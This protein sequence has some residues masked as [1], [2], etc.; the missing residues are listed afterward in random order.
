MAQATITHALRPGS[1]AD[2]IIQG[3][4]A[5]PPSSRKRGRHNTDVYRIVGDAAKLDFR[6]VTGEGRLLLD[7][8][9][10]AEG[11][12]EERITAL[13]A[14]CAAEVAEI[15]AADDLANATALGG[16]GGGAEGAG[17]A[18]E[19]AGRSSPRQLTP[20]GGAPSLGPPLSPIPPPPPSPPSSYRA[21]QTRRR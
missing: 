20:G 17:A 9:G 18:G 15:D 2:I 3:S 1:P 14:V 12:K 10:I 11:L 4:S 19:R 13:T 5:F 16:A 7:A 6:A 21:R 8:L